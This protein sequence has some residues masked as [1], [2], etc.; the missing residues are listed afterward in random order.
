MIIRVSGEDQYRLEDARA[1]RVQEL[2]DAVL[3]AVQAGDQQAFERAYR[4]CSTTCGPTA[5]GWQRT[6]SSPPT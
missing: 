2:D 5:R 6:S 3:V 1:A 4:S